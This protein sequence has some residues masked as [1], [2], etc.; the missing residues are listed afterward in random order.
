MNCVIQPQT[1]HRNSSKQQKTATET[2]N[3]AKP[4]T[5]K[6]PLHK[7]KTEIAS[8]KKQSIKQNQK[9]NNQKQISNIIKPT[10]SHNPSKKV[11]INIPINKIIQK[12]ENL[13]MDKDALSLHPS[14][15]SENEDTM[16]VASDTSVVDTFI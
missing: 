12:E 2:S 10:N 4:K 3:S 5:P 16:S 11:K 1:S 15:S 7:K 13:P 8:N 9:L 14:D 6:L